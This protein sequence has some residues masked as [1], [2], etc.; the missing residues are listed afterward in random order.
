MT[1]RTLG[2]LAGPLAVRADRRTDRI[3]ADMTAPAYD[4]NNVFAKILRGELP[5]HK[6]YEDDATIAFMDMMPRGRRSFAGHPED[7]V[8]QHPRRRSGEPGA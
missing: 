4:A 3:E 2:W 6:L 5:S 1:V 8:A 7:A